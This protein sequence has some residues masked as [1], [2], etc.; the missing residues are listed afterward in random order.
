MKIISR[1][2]LSGDTDTVESVLAKVRC[3]PHAA[4][5]SHLYKIL[6]FY[7]SA[8]QT[9]NTFIVCDGLK[10]D[11]TVH[12]RQWSPSLHLHDNVI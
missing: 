5:P 1:C 7:V 6:A 4:Q 8:N 11:A 2:S 12:R 9:K 3:F 10:H